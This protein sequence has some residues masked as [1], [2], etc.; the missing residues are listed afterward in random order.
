MIVTQR[1]LYVI[2]DLLLSACGIVKKCGDGWRREEFNQLVSEQCGGLP[3]AVSID[4]KIAWVASSLHFD[5]PNFSVAPSVCAA[6]MLVAVRTN[7]GLR[8][9]FWE[10]MWRRRRLCGESGQSPFEADQV[11]VVEQEN[12]KYDAELIERMFG[13]N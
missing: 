9:S 5:P 8:K 1:D 2:E 13:G 10:I 12:D 11:D 7:D 6:N 4:Q 3:S